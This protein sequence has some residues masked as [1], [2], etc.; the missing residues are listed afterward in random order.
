MIMSDR[1]CAHCGRRETNHG[2]MVGTCFWKGKVLGPYR[3]TPEKDVV[4][5]DVDNTESTRYDEAH[6]DD[7]PDMLRVPPPIPD[8]PRKRRGRRRVRNAHRRNV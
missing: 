2:K 4:K 6:G 5:K 3:F 8:H 7:Q 1:R